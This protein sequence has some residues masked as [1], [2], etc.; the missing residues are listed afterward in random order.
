MNHVW[1]AA[2][3]ALYPSLPEPRVSRVVG[4]V[5]E[6]TSA[7]EEQALLLTVSLYETTMG[8]RGIPFGATG[9][10]AAV[11][12]Q[13][14]RACRGPMTESEGARSVLRIV[15]RARG[16]CPRAGIDRIL[17]YFHH[18][19]S[20]TADAYSSREARTVVRLLERYRALVQ[21]GH[22]R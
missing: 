19:N 9:R 2:I 12:R 16:L 15:R 7:T 20:C 13:R 17:G 10:R 22:P 21:S 5:L 18:G 11:E 14:E 6:Q 3:L 4:V 8:A 1:I